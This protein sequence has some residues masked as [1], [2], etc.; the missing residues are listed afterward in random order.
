MTGTS[1]YDDNVAQ[2]RELL[3]QKLTGTLYD[4]VVEANAIGLCIKLYWSPARVPVAH[5]HYGYALPMYEEIRGWVVDIDATHLIEGV[6]EP[7]QTILRESVRQVDLCR[8]LEG[9]V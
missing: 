2:L 7:A 1:T 5:L 4:A 3:A 9:V 8:R 6:I